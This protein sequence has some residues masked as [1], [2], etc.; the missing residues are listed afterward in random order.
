MFGERKHDLDT[1]LLFFFLLFLFSCVRYK[2][3]PYLTD[4]RDASSQ[5]PDIQYTN[6]L[7]QGAHAHI[8]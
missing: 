6:L 2:L 1:F 3:G 5:P 4:V 7:A 8:G